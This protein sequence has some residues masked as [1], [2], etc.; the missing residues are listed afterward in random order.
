[1]IATIVAGDGYP[2]RKVDAEPVCGLDFC[3]DCG[4]CLDCYGG[5]PCS[6]DH[7]YHSWII[8]GEKRWALRQAIIDGDAEEAD[9]FA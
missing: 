6:N 8:D 5:D 4:D 1:M 9:Y 2:L 3:D 7:W